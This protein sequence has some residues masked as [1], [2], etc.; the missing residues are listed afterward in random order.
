MVAEQKKEKEEKLAT[1]NKVIN[2]QQK[3]TYPLLPAGNLVSSYMLNG[4]QNSRK[5]LLHRSIILG[6]ITK[7]FRCKKR[8]HAWIDVHGKRREERC[9]DAE[10]KK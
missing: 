5:Q 10:I 9:T 3:I 8:C 4:F 7:I 1:I 2:G 6:Q